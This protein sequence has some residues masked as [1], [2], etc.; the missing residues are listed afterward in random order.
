VALEDFDLDRTLDGFFA[1]MSEPT[2]DGLNTY[3]VARS[4]RALGMTVALSG[5][6][7]DELLGGYP[8]FVNVPRFSKALTIGGRAARAGVKAVVGL[9]PH[10]HWAK[11]CSIIEGDRDLVGI[12]SNYRRV[13]TGGRRTTDIRRPSHPASPF[14][15]VRLLEMREYLQRQLLRDSDAFTM[16]FALE[17]RTPFVDHELL[18]AVVAAGEWPRGR[19]RS[20][21]EALF[22][23]LPALS[24]PAARNQRKRGF[25][26][27]M[28]KWMREALRDQPGAWRDLRPRLEAAGHR[29]SIDEF[30]AGRRHWS[31]LWAPYVLHR[32]VSP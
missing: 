14:S 27:P 11:L 3:V 32:T 30:L 2:V 21:K 29:K 20:Y 5:V 28:A 31:R 6:G 4:A 25:E 24:V 7:G 16:A 12:W 8:S 18:R 19:H 13:M 26:L 17:L 15:V 23:H 9:A 10:R 22:E 1:A